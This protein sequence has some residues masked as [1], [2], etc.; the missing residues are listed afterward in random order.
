[1]K[2]RAVL[3]ALGSAGAAASAVALRPHRR[4]AEFLPP[5]DLALQV[6]ETFDRWRIDTGLV[7]VLPDPSVQAKL[8]KIYNQLLART[9]VAANGQRVML[10]I[11]YGADQ[12][13]DSTAVHRPEFCYA[14]QGFV[15][16]ALGESDLALDGHSLR[17]RRLIGSMNARFE[18]ITY[19]VTLNDRALMP[20]VQRKLEQIRLGLLGQIPDGLLFRVSTIGLE[21]SLSFRVQ[22]EFVAA[23]SRSMAPDLR[24]R[25]FG[26]VQA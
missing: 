13:N 26:R 23:L 2:R 16:K 24:S 12:G 5:I 22:D 10:S 1:M 8:D 17:V 19:W 7:P 21:Q 3:L 14:A 6:P 25:Y 18:P 4:A 9:Y 20:G 15:V 11:A